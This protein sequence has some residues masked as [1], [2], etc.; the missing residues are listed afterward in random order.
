MPLLVSDKLFPIDLEYA[1]VKT[2]SGID[3]ILIIKNEEMSKKYGDKVKK[4]H[5][6]WVQPS[7]KESNDLV[8]QAT[9][10]E[11]F[12][13]ERSL[14]YL[15][16][17][18][19]IPEKFLKMWDITDEAGKPVPCTPITILKLEPNIANALI[20]NFISRTVPSESDLKN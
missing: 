7:W 5:T 17:R 19:L 15:L 2:K 1:E 4:V 6:Q 16:Y 12:A 10:W 9:V 11:Q 18:S 13:G 8:R 14:D 3:C 20:D